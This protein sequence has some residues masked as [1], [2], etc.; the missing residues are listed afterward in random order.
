MATTMSP[1]AILAYFLFPIGP[2]SP[3]NRP[4]CSVC[5]TRYNEDE[6]VPLMLQCGHGF[7][8]DCLTKMFTSSHDTTLT[9]PTCSHSGGSG[10]VEMWDAVVSGGG[11]GGGGRGCKHR[12]AVKKV[13]LR[14][15]MDVDGMQ[16]ELESLRKASM[17][18]R[19]VCTFHG[20]VKMEGSLYLLMDRC[21]GSVQSEMQRNEGRLTLEQ[22]LRCGFT[23]SRSNHVSI[24]IFFLK[25]ENSYSHQPIILFHCSCCDIKFS[26]FL[27]NVDMGLMFPE[28]F[29]KDF[30]KK[31][32]ITNLEASVYIIFFKIGCHR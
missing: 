32:I 1:V 19:N 30:N 26:F 23:V 2:I 31:K 3:T 28:G 7:C 29:S 4:C 10:G 20:V 18:C 27:S 25:L 22:I 21:F 5:H 16:G 9:C 11:G 6:R 12:V 13:S 17:W 24:C 15:D 14:E 8:K